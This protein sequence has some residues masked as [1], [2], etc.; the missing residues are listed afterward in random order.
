VIMIE[1]Y[2]EIRSATVLRATC[3]RGPRKGG[4]RASGA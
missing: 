1:V 2:L 4:R 3:N